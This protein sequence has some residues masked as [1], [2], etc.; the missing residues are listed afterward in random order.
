MKLYILAVLFLLTS[1]GGAT[2]NNQPA[3]ECE[4]NS[5]SIYTISWDAVD[6]TDLSGYKVYYGKSLENI[7]DVDSNNTS[8]ELNSA[9]E[10]F[11]VCDI[12]NVA[13]KAIGYTKSSSALS[14]SVTVT[15]E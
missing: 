1:C 8:W 4:S 6:D 12:I 9:N 10:G 7:A 11:L 5:S 14:T 15:I 13:V 3:N 2:N